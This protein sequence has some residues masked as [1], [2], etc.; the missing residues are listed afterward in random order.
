[1]AARRAAAEEL[2]FFMADSHMHSLALV[3]G[4]LLCWQS[5]DAV[6]SVLESLTRVTGKCIFIAWQILCLCTCGQMGEKNKQVCGICKG[7]KYVLFKLDTSALS[8]LART[9]EMTVIDQNNLVFPASSASCRLVLAD[10]THLQA[11]TQAHL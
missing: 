2:T 3:W 7:W 6:V 9:I 1:L 11:C 4:N 5:I 10:P 8:G